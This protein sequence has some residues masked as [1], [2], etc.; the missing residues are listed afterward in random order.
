MTGKVITCR[1]QTKSNRGKKKFNY[2]KTLNH[3]HSIGY[4]VNSYLQMFHGKNTQKK[5]I[6]KC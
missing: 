2:E 5:K 4:S 1:T 3:T 6:L